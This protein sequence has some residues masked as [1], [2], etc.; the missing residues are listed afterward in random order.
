MLLLSFITAAYLNSQ[1]KIRY[2]TQHY[3]FFIILFRERIGKIFVTIPANSRV[4]SYRTEA[5]AIVFTPLYPEGPSLWNFTLNG[6]SDTV[7]V[8]LCAL[9]LLVAFFLNL[10]GQML[11]NWLKICID[12]ECVNIYQ[13]T[14]T[15]K[16][17]LPAEI[18]YVQIYDYPQLTRE[19][20]AGFPE[21]YL[22]PAGA[23]VTLQCNPTNIDNQSV[24]F[25]INGT[26]TATSMLSYLLPDTNLFLLLLVLLLFCYGCYCC[27]WYC[28]CCGCCCCCCCDKPLEKRKFENGWGL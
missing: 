3:G 16:K 26:L 6:A 21:Y 11:L 27:W 1:F 15:I 19:H 5:Y 20:S 23:N 14:L 17:G 25:V 24:R 7:E 9:R 2:F 12:D 10:T 8:F 18:L 4:N 28:S 13:Y 22:A